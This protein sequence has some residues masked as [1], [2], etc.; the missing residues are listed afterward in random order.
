MNIIKNCKECE[1]NP[2]S[3]NCVCLDLAAAPSPSVPAV[4]SRPL[5]PSDSKIFSYVIRINNRY[6]C[7][8]DKAKRVK[9]AWSLAG[10]QF[11]LVNLK[12]PQDSKLIQAEEKL[13]AKNIKFDRLVVSL[14]EQSK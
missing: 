4:E 10:A 7:G 1:L 2:D 6:F 5:I 11:F 3:C 9:T 8:F 14:Q 12:F 13:I